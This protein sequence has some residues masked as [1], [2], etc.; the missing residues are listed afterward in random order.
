MFSGLCISVD[1]QIRSPT[2]QATHVGVVRSMT[3]NSAHIMERLS[4]H[5]G[6]V[7][8]VLH[9]GLAG[10]HRANPAASLMVEKMYCVSVLL[11]GMGRLIMSTKDETLLNQ[12]YKVHLQ[13]LLRLHQDTPAPVVFFLAGCLPLQTQLHLRMFSL[14]GQLCRLR[15]GDYL[16]VEHALQVYSCIS[17]QQVLVLEAQ[18]A[19]PPVWATTPCRP[20]KYANML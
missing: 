1:D 7:F 12:R 20:L 19:L 8:S 13:R 15:E 9:D 11:S 10:G 5:R 4:A 14:F 3:G 6:A 16:L 2:I 17:I 18:A